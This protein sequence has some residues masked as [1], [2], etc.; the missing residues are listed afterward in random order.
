M[1]RSQSIIIGVPSTEIDP[2][3]AKMVKDVQPGGFILFSRNIETP[4]QLRKLV[5]DLFEL[6]DEPPFIMIDQEGGRVARIREL[7]SE[8]P[9]GRELREKGDISLVREHGLLTGQMLSLFNINFNLCP[10]VDISIGEERENSL[11]NRCYGTTAE[12]VIRNASAFNDAMQ[13]SGVFSCAKH[14]PSYTHAACD[15]HHDLPRI[16]RTREELESFDWKPFKAMVDQ[17]DSF[18]MGHALYPKVEKREVPSSLSSFFVNHLLRDEWGFNKLVVTDD[19]DMGAILNYFSFADSIRE[20]VKAGNDLLLICHRTEKAYEAAEAL[21][22]VDAKVVETYL[23]RISDAKSRIPYCNDF[24]ENRFKDL[25]RQT[26]ELRTKVVGA[27]KA[28]QKSA[29]D[30]KRSPV[31]EY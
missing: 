20:A 12:E 28:M 7:G 24:S 14:F 29:E 31:E 1:N 3:F 5:D 10:L 15:P 23:E 6:S 9:S 16:Q 30:G 26:L 22:S 17:V 11:K 13:E 25:D 27:D 4:T 21:K 18:M 2:D 8:P 19:L